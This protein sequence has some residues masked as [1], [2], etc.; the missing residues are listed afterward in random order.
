MKLNRS[1]GLAPSRHLVDAAMDSYVTWREECLRVRA[2][3]HNW[4]WARPEDRARTFDEYVEALDREENAAEE[5]GHLVGR[6]GDRR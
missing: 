4:K 3:Y 5:Y 1:R 2:A 6:A